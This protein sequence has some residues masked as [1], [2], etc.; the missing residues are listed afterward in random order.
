M[1]FI[2]VLTVAAC[3]QVSTAGFAQN[4]EIQT[5]P[6][7]IPS[8]YIDIHGRVVDENGK[9]LSGATVTVKATS[10]RTVTGSKGKFTIQ[11][12]SGQ[13]L[14]ISNVGYDDREIIID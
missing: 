10:K 4:A 7:N 13:T 14:I 3:L 1:K 5:G 2:L 6:G 11:A 9:P 12:D 8:T